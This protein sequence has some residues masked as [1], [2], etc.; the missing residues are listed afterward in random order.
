MYIPSTYNYNSIFCFYIANISLYTGLTIVL[1]IFLFMVIFADSKK[2]LNCFINTYQLIVKKDSR[3]LI[4]TISKR[5][6]VFS[7]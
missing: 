1:P 7:F 4:G 2:K 5:I 3:Y 6:F